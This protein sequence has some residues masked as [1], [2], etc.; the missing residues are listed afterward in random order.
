MELSAPTI[1]WVFVAPL[2]LGALLGL[3]SMRRRRLAP[4]SGESGSVG[5]NL[6]ATLA[7]GV[8]ALSA[9]WGV[10][11]SMDSLIATSDGRMRAAIALVAAI[12]VVIALTLPLLKLPGSILV[13]ITAG[14]G[15]VAALVA[16]WFVAT[17]ALG[18]GEYS[19]STAVKL[20]SVAGFALGGMLAAGGLALLR[21]AG[22]RI[23]LGA[24]LAGWLLSI[25]AAI[26]G[27][28][29]ISTGQVAI[30][31]GLGA[32]GVLG[33]VILFRSGSIGPAPIVAAAGLGAAYISSGHF[34]A[35]TPAWLGLGLTLVPGVAFIAGL[36]ARRVFG[37]ST[38]PWVIAGV[39]IA[40][41]AAVAG[42]LVAPGL[43]SLASVQSHE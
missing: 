38:K 19:A 41:A 3:I 1:I 2:V 23:A 30:G 21:S 20:G 5:A 25:G 39:Q 9:H 4:A 12:G 24:V 33:S 43:A 6:G 16:G 36:L 37:A 34:T 13:A 27:T 28:G 14:L 35:S 18:P 11:G 10:F 8:A 32:L 31:T 7:L 22:A 15:S 40:A 26:F 42:A 29:S 17:R